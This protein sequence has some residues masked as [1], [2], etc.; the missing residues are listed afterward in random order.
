[1][2]GTFTGALSTKC[3][4]V[5]LLYVLVI[6][7]WWHSWS[8]LS[9][10]R[11]SINSP[12]ITEVQT[13]KHAHTDRL[14]AFGLQPVPVMETHVALCQEQR[15]L[16]AFNNTRLVS[17]WC[18]NNGGQCKLFHHS[19]G[20]LS[21]INSFCTCVHIV[22][23]VFSNSQRKQS[24]T[25]LEAICVSVWIEV[26][27]CSVAGTALWRT[28]GVVLMHIQLQHA[29]NFLHLCI[30]EEEKT[31]ECSVWRGGFFPPNVV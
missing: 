16:F 1:M 29:L 4:P 10:A 20:S 14:V 17:I 18:I 23:S 9:I 12:Q 7:R 6:H 8:R 24:F 21:C 19:S 30:R 13:F 28:I 27:G 11:C 25:N 3:Q 2:I 31:L 5:G 26:V 15:G 22:G